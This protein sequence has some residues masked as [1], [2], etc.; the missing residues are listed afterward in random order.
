MSSATQLHK[1]LKWLRQ[2]WAGTT[3]VLSGDWSRPI[4]S[5]H[6][7]QLTASASL[8]SPVQ[9]TTR[10]HTIVITGCS[11][12]NIPTCVLQ[13][14]ITI[15]LD[16]YWNSL[17]Y[18]PIFYCIA[19]DCFYYYVVHKSYL[20]TTYNGLPY[21]KDRFQI[22]NLIISLLDSWSTWHKL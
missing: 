7:R 1:I 3:F 8:L 19:S 12:R 11:Q 21:F 10:T 6:V 17:Q 18:L 5:L 2:P 22:H 14:Y 20:Q 16:L 15:L 4:R 13:H 9:S